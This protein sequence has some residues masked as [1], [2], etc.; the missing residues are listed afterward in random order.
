MRQATLGSVSTDS[1]LLEPLTPP[2]P[3]VVPEDE[4]SRKAFFEG[5]SQF[6]LFCSPQDDDHHLHVPPQTLA[7]YLSSNSQLPWQPASLETVVE[8]TG[9]EVLSPR[10]S[11]RLSAHMTPRLTSPLLSID[12]TPTHV[13]TW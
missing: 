6:C 12:H 7:I 3:D 8:E 10:P 5:H 1:H 2:P 9:N 13:C 11:S 4:V